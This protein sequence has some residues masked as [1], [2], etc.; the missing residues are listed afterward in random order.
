MIEFISFLIF[1][2]PSLPPSLPP[3]LSSSLPL[4]PGSP[5]P[6]SDQWGEGTAHLHLSPALPHKA[7]REQGP[8]HGNQLTVGWYCASQNVS[9]FPSPWPTRVYCRSHTVI[10]STLFYPLIRCDFFIWLAAKLP[11]CGLIPSPSRSSFYL[12]AVVKNPLTFSPW[13]RDKNWG[14]KDWEQG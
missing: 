4:L 14:G 5:H 10:Q 11:V 13:L 6:C 7:S 1:L 3:F 9:D 8:R 12:A 2:A